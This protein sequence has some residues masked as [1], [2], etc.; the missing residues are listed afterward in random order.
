MTLREN[1]E[2]MTCDHKEKQSIYSI[3]LVK[4]HHY[5]VPSVSA[6]PGTVLLTITIV[7]SIIFCCYTGNI[8]S[9]EWLPKK[10]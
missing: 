5:L 1:M 3:S 2:L 7:N 10:L 4:F 9:T 6:V 8:L